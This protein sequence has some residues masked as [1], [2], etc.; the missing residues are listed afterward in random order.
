LRNIAEHFHVSTT[1]LFRHKRSHLPQKLAL[2]KQHKETLSAENLLTEMADL[3]DRLRRGVEQ[4]EATANPAAFVAF[5]R[6]LRQS[7]ESYFA[8]SE[9]IAQNAR[10]SGGDGNRLVIEV[11]DLGSLKS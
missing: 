9:K 11:R 4:A 5:A 7:L 6:E 10:G 1:A 3:K 2:A 8:I